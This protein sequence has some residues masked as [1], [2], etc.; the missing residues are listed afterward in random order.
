VIRIL[1]ASACLVLASC[2]ES[3]VPLESGEKF[4]DAALIGTWKTDLDGDPSIATI[5]RQVNGDLVAD[6]QAYWEPGPTAS[7]VRFQLVLARFGE[8]RYVSFRSA[9]MGPQY[10]LARYIFQNRNRFCLHAAYSERLLADLETKT[11]PGAL[12]P[13][14]HVSNVELS[15]SAGELRD[16]FSRHGA[17]AFHDSPLMAFERVKSAKLPP[18][19]SQEDID[20]RAPDG[21]RD[22]TPCRR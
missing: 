19:R 21:F 6:V 20:R 13:D 14:R 8:H 16:Y 3:P 22:I 2:V 10:A 7:T 15:A 11:L 4:F 5:Y 18:P 1:V 9:D 17:V 12:K